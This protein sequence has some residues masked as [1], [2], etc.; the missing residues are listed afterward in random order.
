MS[1]FSNTSAQ[2]LQK[3]FSGIIPPMVTP[4]IDD[5]TLDRPG[6]ERLIEHLIEGGVQ[7]I[8]DLVTTGEAPSLS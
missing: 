8:F 5:R 2:Q 4:L 6:L 3:A 7:G 1:V